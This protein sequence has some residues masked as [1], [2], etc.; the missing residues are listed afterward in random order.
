[1][2]AGR[3]GGTGKGIEINIIN[4]ELE[5]EIPGAFKRLRNHQFVESEIESRGRVNKV[6]SQS[7]REG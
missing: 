6:L 7:M 2:V 3:M 1:M 5:K 4:F